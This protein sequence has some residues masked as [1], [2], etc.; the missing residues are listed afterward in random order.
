MNPLSEDTMMAAQ[1]QILPQSFFNKMDREF[2]INQRM[3]AKKIDQA[4]AE[5]SDI[6]TVSQEETENIQNV[7]HYALFEALNEALDQERPYKNKGEPMPW[8]KNTRVV[9]QVSTQ[10][11]AKQILDKAKE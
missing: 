11:Q 6:L 2:V 3:K 7:H 8:S 10:E 5:E 1:Q 9:K 4:T